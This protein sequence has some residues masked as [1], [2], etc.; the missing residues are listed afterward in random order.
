MG[1]SPPQ[2]QQIAG[3]FHLIGSPEL[4]IVELPVLLG[5]GSAD[6]GAPERRYVIHSDALA[7]AAVR[8]NKAGYHGDTTINPMGGAAR[9]P[10]GVAVVRA[11]GSRH[12]YHGY[13]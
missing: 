1:A 12:G 4:H 5:W 10:G 13:E 8:A 7:A 6:T 9:A 2:P 3:F 11:S